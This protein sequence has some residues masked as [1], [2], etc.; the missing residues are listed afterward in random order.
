MLIAREKLTTYPKRTHF[1]PA[2][3]PRTSAT[4]M[5]SSAAPRQNVFVLDFDGVIV[6][7]E[8]EVSLAGLEASCSYWPDHFGQLGQADRDRLL[9]GLRAVRSQLVKGVENMVFARL[10]LED[11]ENEPKIRADSR[12]AIR[13]ALARWG[14]TLDQL[15]PHF[16]SSR[17]SVMGANLD[18][19]LGLQQ[20]Y[21]GVRYGQCAPLRPQPPF[22][23]WQ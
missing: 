12:G 6:D 8:P 5:P 19:W 14:C 1:P 13:E 7:S 15:N 20:I 22:P 21:P 23:S 16:E 3:I 2:R 18:F 10:L 4:I 9:Q 17:N 11:P